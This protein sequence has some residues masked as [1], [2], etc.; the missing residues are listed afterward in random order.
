MLVSVLQK[1]LKMLILSLNTNICYPSAEYF[2][3]PTPSG[4]CIRPKT[5]VTL[6]NKT[7]PPCHKQSKLL[8]YSESTRI[9]TPYGVDVCSPLQDI[10]QH[11]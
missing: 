4:S 3:L 7:G 9:A 6:E 11:F 1:S 2:I 10:L 8:Y 5:K